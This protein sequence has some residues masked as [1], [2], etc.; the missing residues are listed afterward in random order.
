MQGQRRAQIGIND[1]H[2]ALHLTDSHQLAVDPSPDL[3]ISPDLGC[4]CLSFCHGVTGGRKVRSS[5]SARQSAL[6]W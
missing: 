5:V 1:P 6:L 2:R 3:V 4:C